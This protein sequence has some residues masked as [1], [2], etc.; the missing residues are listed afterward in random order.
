MATQCLTRM[1]SAKLY[2]D[3]NLPE[4]LHKSTNFLCISKGYDIKIN[5]DD[6]TELT[7]EHQLRK[8]F[9]ELVDPSVAHSFRYVHRLDF[10]TSGIL[11]LALNRNAAKHLSHQFKN[12]QVLKYYLAL[13][14]GHV[15]DDIVFIDVPTGDLEDKEWPGRRCVSSHPA[16]KDPKITHTLVIA[17]EK[18]LFDGSPA[19]KVVLKPITGKQH[20]LRVHCDYIGNTIV[21]D[22]TYS[23]RQDTS[24]DRMMLHSYR[25]STSMPIEDLDLISQDPFTPDCIK[26]WSPREIIRTYEEAERLGNMFDPHSS[27]VKKVEIKEVT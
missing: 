3:G 5:Y 19:T 14:R 22:Y 16:C 15:E 21:G 26:E 13:V 2:K 4:V 8:M 27:D 20:Q 18:G 1:L 12:K 9:P 23:L 11:C 25:L 17:L 7:V 24:P 10:A 6:P